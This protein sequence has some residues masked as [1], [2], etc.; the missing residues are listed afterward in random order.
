MEK[1]VAISIL[2][3]IYEKLQDTKNPKE[4][5]L[6]TISTYRKNLEIAT[7]ENLK[8]LIKKHTEYAKKYGEYDKKTLRLS[9]KIDKRMRKIFNN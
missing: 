9:K 3:D 1:T 4:K 7:N 2:E 8:K 5:G 6:L